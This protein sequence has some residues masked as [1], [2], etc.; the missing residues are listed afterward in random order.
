MSSVWQKSFFKTELNLVPATKLLCRKI[1]FWLTKITFVDRMEFVET[2]LTF[3]H[4]RN[5]ATR[6]QYSRRI[7]S[8]KRF[9]SCLV[10]VNPAANQ[11]HFS[12]LQYCQLCMYKVTSIREQIHF[13]YKMYGSLT[14]VTFC[15]I[16]F[17]L[18]VGLSLLIG[19]KRATYTVA[20]DRI[21]PWKESFSSHR[22]STAF[23]KHAFRYKSTWAA[24]GHNII[25]TDSRNATNWC[26]TSLWLITV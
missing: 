17:P 14:K 20:V 23:S 12:E 22:I 1:D 19:I 24:P 26:H 18:V 8:R 25:E 13:L 2:K 15:F 5:I 6:W 9:T 16:L 21:P 3:V 4:V 11:R 10:G 7:C